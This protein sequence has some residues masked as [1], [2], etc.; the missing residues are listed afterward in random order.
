MG[1]RDA[2]G[3][4]AAPMMDT[5]LEHVDFIAGGQRPNRFAEPR[6]SPLPVAR[7]SDRATGCV[8]KH[9]DLPGASGSRPAAIWLTAPL[10]RNP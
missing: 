1:D 9:D 6:S 3:A 7:L 2:G 5:Y 10:P 8:L 4:S